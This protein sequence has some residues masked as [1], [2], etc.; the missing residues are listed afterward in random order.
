MLLAAQH[1]LQKTTR[2]HL[3]GGSE[4]EERF[5][6]I[7]LEA[8]QKAAKL[9]FKLGSG[10]DLEDELAEELARKAVESEETFLLIFYED[11]ASGNYTTSELEATWRAGLY[12]RRLVGTANTAWLAT[13]EDNVYY[14]WMMGVVEKHCGDCP[15]LAAGGPYRAADLPTVPG[16]GETECTVGCCCYL[17]RLSDG[18]Q[19]FGFIGGDAD[20]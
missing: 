13:G 4:F 1:A 5:H 7:L 2:E 6:D 16:A 8:H 18:A 10:T 9:G 3:S 14:D 15:V 17:V 12:A 20:E 11:L 19:S